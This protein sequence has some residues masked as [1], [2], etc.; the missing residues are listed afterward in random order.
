MKNKSWWQRA[1]N[2]VAGALAKLT[3]VLLIIAVVAVIVLAILA[4]ELIP[5]TVAAHRAGAVGHIRRAVG[6]LRCPDG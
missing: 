2:S 1:L 4:P 5:R 6:G 3:I